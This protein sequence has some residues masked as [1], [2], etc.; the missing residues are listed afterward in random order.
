M[1]VGPL[2]L[3]EI[4]T[5]GIYLELL[6]LV[7]ILIISSYIFF[8]TSYIYRLTNHLGIFY[9]RTGFAFIGVSSLI[10]IIQYI[11]IL[12]K[13]QKIFMGYFF[14]IPY[15]SQI[16]SI[17]GIIYL[18]MSIVNHKSI[19]NIFK[20][21]K[22]L[23]ASSVVIII[24]SLILFTRTQLVYFQLIIILIF[25]IFLLISIYFHKN[26]KFLGKISSIYLLLFIFWTFNLTQFLLQTQF[27]TREISAILSIL[28]FIIIGIIFK[29][30][31][32]N[33]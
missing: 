9:F 3:S 31:I 11:F 23:I 16:F 33:L 4:S 7:L 18:F 21:K 2:R 10:S 12:F 20:N 22:I 24:F 8:K 1:L 15:F 29:Q 25:S 19:S 30:N 14:I 27:L 5:I 28:I 13:F 26:K 17:I 6:S 32:K